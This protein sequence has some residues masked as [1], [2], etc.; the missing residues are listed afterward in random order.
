MALEP[1]PDLFD[2]EAGLVNA[3][4]DMELY[5]DVLQL[6]LKGAKRNEEQMREYLDAG[7]LKNYG[8]LVHALKNNLRTVGAGAA[9]ELAF[10]QEIHS[11]NGELDYVKEHHAELVDAMALAKRYIRQYLWDKV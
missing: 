3:A 10:D 8:I 2:A 6:F 9:G 5:I 1:R 4:D 7:D 11:R